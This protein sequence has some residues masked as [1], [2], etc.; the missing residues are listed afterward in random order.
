VI[1]LLVAY[2]L[3]ASALAHLNNPYA[4]LASIYEYQLVPRWAAEILAATLPFLHIAIAF[5]LI[6]RY[7]QPKSFAVGGLLF[8]IYL[9]AQST[10]LIQGRD[11]GCGCF[12]FMSNRDEQELIGWK[13]T[14]IAGISAFACLVG[15]WTS[16]KWRD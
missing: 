5:C 3:L 2:G 9:C 4:F 14:S 6:G 13:S 8:T 10:A 16:Y 11:I 1:G 7:Q 15:W 12:G